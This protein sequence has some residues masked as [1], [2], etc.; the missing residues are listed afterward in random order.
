[1]HACP[2]CYEQLSFIEGLLSA[3]IALRICALRELFEE[4]GILLAKDQHDGTECTQ[5]GTRVPSHFTFSSKASLLHWRKRVHKNAYN[6][7]NMCKLVL[8]YF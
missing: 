2:T 1:M 3:Q 4:T 5:I 7:I 6:F 8:L